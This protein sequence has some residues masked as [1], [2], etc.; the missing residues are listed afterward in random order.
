MAQVAQTLPILV[1][2]DAGSS[3]Y[4]DNRE[5]YWIDLV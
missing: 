2:A 5:E 4:I 1:D 3:Q